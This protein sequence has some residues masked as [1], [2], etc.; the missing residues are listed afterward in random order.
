MKTLKVM[1]NDFCVNTDDGCIWGNLI[2]WVMA[3]KLAYKTNDEFF[4]DPNKCIRYE[5]NIMDYNA[6]AYVWLKNYSNGD[7]YFIELK[8]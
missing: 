7:N 6:K 2:D 4:T 8:H 5:K 3:N 1:K